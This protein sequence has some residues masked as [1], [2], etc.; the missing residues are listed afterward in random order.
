MLSLLLCAAHSEPKTTHTVFMNLTIDGEP[1]GRVVIGLYGELLPRTV[2]NFVHLL[3][4]DLGPDAAGNGRCLR[5]SR[6]HRIIP[7]LMIQGGDYVHGTG[8]FSESI[9]GST[10]ED[11]SFRVGFDGPGRLAMASSARGGNGCQFFIT[12][13]EAARYNGRHVV[14]G[15]VMGGMQA[16]F[17]VAK[18]GTKRGRPLKEVRIADCGKF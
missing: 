9:W 7:T 14:F 17:E 13:K 2:E 6:F 4:C 8:A 18:H 15:R 16:V 3:A 10:F 12:V 1:A 5:G 11:E